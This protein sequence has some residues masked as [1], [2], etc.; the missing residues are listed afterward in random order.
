MSDLTLGIVVRCM[1]GQESGDEGASIGA[2]VQQA[3][4][5]LAARFWSLAPNWTERLPTRTN[6]QFLCAVAA[7][8]G[9]VERIISQRLRAAEPGS[10]LL[11]MLLAAQGEAGIG[12]DPHQV[13]DEVMTM[14]LAGHET[15]AAAL[16][17]TWHLLSEAPVCCGEDLSRGGSGSWPRS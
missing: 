16:T 5:W 14:L 9:A 11:G 17:W 15:S 8:N 4:A 1:F 2:A 13:R 7:L 3:Q 6:R 10:D 12:I